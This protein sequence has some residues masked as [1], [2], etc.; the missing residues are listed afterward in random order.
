MVHF[1]GAA[2]V[3]FNCLAFFVR[4]GDDWFRGGQIGVFGELRGP[5]EGWEAFPLLAPVVGLGED[6]FGAG[7]A[8]EGR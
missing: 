3:L 8:G 6:V 7:T 4:G 5:G 1:H 2:L